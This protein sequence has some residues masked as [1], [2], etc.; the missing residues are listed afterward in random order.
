MQ[1]AKCGFEN[2]PEAKY[3]GK[4]GDPLQP[5]GPAPSESG[6]SP[7]MK[8]AIGI[9]SA[10]IPLL[11]IIMGAIYMNDPNPKK[12]EVGKLWLFISL[13]ALALWCVCGVIS[14]MVGNHPNYGYN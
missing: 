13:G 9:A 4:C 10:I 6:V 11:G 12:K 5:S 3:C 7:E 1:C 2:P 8:I 14:A